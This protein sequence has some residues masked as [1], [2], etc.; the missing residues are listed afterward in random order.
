MDAAW[1]LEQVTGGDEYTEYAGD[2]LAAA[3]AA[4][5]AGRGIRLTV[6]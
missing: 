3:R 2:I 6:V 4:A 1:G 5:L